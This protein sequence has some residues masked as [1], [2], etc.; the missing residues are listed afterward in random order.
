[1]NIQYDNNGQ[2]FVAFEQMPPGGPGTGGFKRAWIRKPVPGSPVD[3]AGTG[4]Y[5]N[6]GMTSGLGGG[7]APGA[8]FPIFDRN[9]P[10]DQVLHA[11]VAAVCGITGGQIP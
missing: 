3:W 6:V 2:P 11:F 5:V 10:D 4:R 9:L 7:P 8:D 1:M